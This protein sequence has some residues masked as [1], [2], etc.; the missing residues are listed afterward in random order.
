MGKR[1]CESLKN[2]YGRAGRAS[3]VKG[4]TITSKGKSN[5]GNEKK[6]KS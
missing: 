2:L 6:E 1:P 4:P 3:L 5:G